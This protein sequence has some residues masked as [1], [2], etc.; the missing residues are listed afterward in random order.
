[1]RALPTLLIPALLAAP[2]ATFADAPAPT[3][4]ETEGLASVRAFTL[5]HSTAL[6]TEAAALRDRVAAY[7]GIIAAHDGDYQSAWDADGATLAQAIRDIRANWLATHNEY[8]TIEGIVAGLPRT[9]DYDLILDAGNPGT[10]D[11]DVADYDLTLPDGT[12]LH[13]PGNLFHTLSEPVLWGTNPDA[14]RLAVDLDGDGAIGAGEMLFDPNLA[15]GAAEGLAFW[16]ADL[17]AQV[18]SWEPTRDDAFTAVVTM[19][20]TIGDYFGEWKDS[21]YLG[22]VGESFVAQ[23]RLVDVAGIMNGCQLMYES[24]IS[25]VLAE[26]GDSGLDAVI[27]SSFGQMLDLVSDTHAREQAGES[28]SAEEADALAAE[29]QDIADRIVAQVLQAAARYDV[30]IED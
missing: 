18:E 7:A 24:A 28:F 27:R 8:E 26:A 19:T 5:E 1:M 11:D 20:P 25:P 9:A 10:E 17:Q 29:S 22:G 13:Q 23:S 6:A 12:E 15:L 16:T 4:A 30:T 3:A 2:A 21:Q 14:V